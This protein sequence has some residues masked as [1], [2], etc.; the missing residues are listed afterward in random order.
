MMD[1]DHPG[2]SQAGLIV[3]GLSAGY[4]PGMPIINNVDIIAQRGEI[5]TIIGPNG[6]GKST[7]IKS[8]AGLLRVEK[9]S[10]TFDGKNITGIR[11]DKLSHSGVAMVPQLDNIFRTMS[12]QQNLRLAG[13]RCQV[14]WRQAVDEMLTRF[15]VLAEKHKAR[16]GSLSGGQRQFLAIAMALVASPD[17]LLLDEPSAGLSPKAALEVLGMLGGIADSQVAIVMVEQNAK[18]ALTVSDRAYILAEGR[19]QYE[20]VASELLHDPVLGQIYLGARRA[21]AHATESV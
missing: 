18:A 2:S 13:R 9:G 5:V 4:V 7:L 17:L 16:A 6:A 20:G 15:P 14:H 1:S 19:N 8:I 11:P 12:V 21:E 10:I 3:N